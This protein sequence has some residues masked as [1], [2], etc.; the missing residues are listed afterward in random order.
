MRC[1]RA[2]SSIAAAVLALAGFAAAAA[3]EPRAALSVSAAEQA[4]LDTLEARDAIAAIDSGLW[5]AFDGRDRAGWQA[6]MEARR[7][8]L[9]AALGRLDAGRLSRADAAAVA[10]MRRSLAVYDGEGAPDAGQRPCADAARSDLGYDG[11]R[12]ALLGCYTEIGSRLQFEG[13]TVDRGTVRQ[14]LHTVEGPGRRKALFEAF[15]PLW[16]AVNGD[17]TAGSPYRRMIALAAADDAVHGSQA[18]AAART[19]GVPAAE[20]ENWLLRVLETWAAAT[21]PGM[22][23]PWDYSYVNGEAN[24]LL[25]AKTPPQALAALNARFYRDLG[26]DPAALGTVYDLAPRADKSPLAYTDFLRRGRDVDGRWRAPVARVV[27]SY[28]QGGLFALNEIVH[29]TGH[30]VHL[31]AIRARPAYMDGPAEALFVEAFADVPSWSVYQPDWQRRYLGEALARPLS[32]RA[33]FGDVMLDVAWALFEIRMLRDPSSDPNAV[34]TDITARY[35]HIV[36]HPELAWWAQR[37]QLVM[38]PGYM[39]NYGLGGVLT[40]EIRE[41]VVRGVGRFDTGNHRW[42]RW[43]G[44]RLLRYGSERDSRQL[45]VGLLGRPPSPRILIGQIRGIS[46]R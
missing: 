5:P 2:A 22:V 10:A 11:L 3:G 45:V 36:P 19:V 32:L 37:V 8:E 6:V 12:S 28:P 44:Q 1:S 43:L 40:A 25:A 23:E 30:A 46:A 33:L 7:A 29:E 9:D 35:L 31:S 4:F 34:W 16:S 21:G 26:A 20:L 39:V 14:L 18:E 13:A 38:A 24:R 15:V 17:G 42:Y 27:G 41:A